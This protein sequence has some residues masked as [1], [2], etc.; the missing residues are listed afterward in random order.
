MTDFTSPTNPDDSELLAAIRDALEERNRNQSTADRI[1]QSNTRSVRNLRDS[2]IGFVTPMT[3]LR[4]SL[5]RMDE[6][7]RKLTAMGTTYS[8]FQASLEKNSK[9]TSESRVS[10]RALTAE[11]AKNYEQGI[12]IN[13]GAVRDL[14]E[15]MIATGQNIVG[16][17]QMQSNAVLQTGNNTDAIQQIHRANKEVSDKYGVSND[18]LIESLNSLKSTMDAV[19]FFGPQAVTSFD[20]IATELKG[21]V[22]GANITGGLQ[23]MMG[24]LTPGMDNM[25]AS[26]LLGVGGVRQKTVGGGGLDMGDIDLFVSNFERI[27]GSAQG[28]EVGPDVAAAQMQ[29]PKQQVVSLMHMINLLKTNNA[30]SK[31]DQATEREKFNNLKTLREKQNDW[32]DNGAVKM[33]S[34]LGTMDTS[35]L[36]LAGGALQAGGILRA[37]GVGVTGG[38]RGAGGIAGGVFGAGG[39]RAGF[40]RGLSYGAAGMAGAGMLGHATG[41][42]MSMTGGLAMAGSMIAP[43]VGTAV[44]ATVGLLIDIAQHTLGS[45]EAAKERVKQE[46]EKENRERAKE[47]SKDIQRINFMTGYIRSRSSEQLASDPEMLLANQ[48]TATELTRLRRATEAANKLAALTKE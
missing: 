28:M 38:A 17:R 16:L 9:V 34:T 10:Q 33:L 22:G 43:G 15:E 24:I 42:D 27:M 47:N 2:L 45:S 37:A 21:R 48:V 14:T 46:E 41:M 12:R 1:Y 30:M 8:K 20:I 18:R 35:L 19:S 44:G 40:G 7:N 13:N 31:E 36:F 6:T 4:A 25:A 26:R 32:Y 3:R 23:A 5:T 39:V 29:I 11:L